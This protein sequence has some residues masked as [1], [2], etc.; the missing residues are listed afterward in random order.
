MLNMKH[1]KLNAYYSAGFSL[2]E[3]ML[4]ML[5]GIIILGGVMSLYLTTRDTQRSS[6][7]QLALLGDARFAIETISFDLRHTGIWGETN[8]WKMIAC[9]K[10]SELVCADA[11]PAATADCAT[12]EYINFMAPL[13][14]SDGVNPFG[15]TCATKSYKA[16]TDVLGVRYADSARIPTASLAANVAYVRSNIMNGQ[17][18]FGSTVP[19]AMLYKW[20]D[21][22]TTH[23]H[24][25][26]S[27]AYYVSTYTNTSGD[28][29]PS[30]HRVSL[31]AGPVMNDELILPGVENFQ[32]EFGIDTTGDMQVNTYVNA[33]NVPNWSD[34]SVQAVKIWVLVRSRRV[35]RDN[36][37]SAQTFTIASDTPVTYPNDG[38]RRMLVSSVVKLRNMSRVD[39][40][41]AGGT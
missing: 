3:L 1:N 32:I 18:F 38:Y 5:I 36:I 35:D 31:A 7:D 13:S 22:S 14:G 11:M 19:T 30:L 39:L 10:D 29:L 26:V 9:H 20:N 4:A 25:L 40:Q 23:N 28:G 37:S 8:E 16:G 12:S 33:S 15:S 6:E 17:V 41:S 24:V 34:G 2:I 27:R 21:D